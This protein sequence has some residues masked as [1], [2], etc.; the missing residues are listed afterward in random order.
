MNSI[1]QMLRDSL[2]FHIDHKCRILTMVALLLLFSVRRFALHRRRL[3]DRQNASFYHGV[4]NSL[5]KFGTVFFIEVAILSQGWRWVDDLDL[6]MQH[7]FL[8]A[9]VP[10]LSDSQR[11]RHVQNWTRFLLP[12]S[13][14]AL[15]VFVC[16][17]LLYCSVTSLRLEG[18]KLIVA[19]QKKSQ[20]EVEENRVS[21]DLPES[22]SER[23]TFGK[24]ET[25][26]NIIISLFSFWAMMHWHP[27]FGARFSVKGFQVLLGGL[28]VMATQVCSLMV[29]YAISICV[30]KAP[31]E[32]LAGRL[33]VSCFTHIYGMLV[34]LFAL[35][36][37]L[38][39]HE[40]LVTYV[41]KVYALYFRRM[42][43]KDALARDIQVQGSRIV[44]SF[45]NYLVDSTYATIVA[46]ALRESTFE[47]FKT[48]ARSFADMYISSY[49]ILLFSAVVFIPCVLASLALV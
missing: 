36:F 37:Y 45:A 20:K 43:N 28:F 13:L 47:V 24:T 7:Y 14:N 17:S 44:E 32:Y 15:A 46:D 2:P 35:V 16:C 49:V 9:G 5:L 48:Q 1:T 26:G 22:P 19:R 4:L 34:I 11:V 42:T 39:S 27:T 31:A 21:F 18:I 41:Y 33:S 40:I 10:D 30:R 25:I 12:S 6:A 8:L 3:E 38:S 29:F 23:I